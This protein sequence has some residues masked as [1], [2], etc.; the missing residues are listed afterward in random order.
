MERLFLN[1]T[2]G[3]LAATATVAQAGL[4][5]TTTLAEVLAFQQGL[6]VQTFEN[7]SGRTPFAVDA[8]PADGVALGSA[9][10]VYDQVPG[11][12]FS[13][14]FKPGEVMAGLFQVQV[15]NG[16]GDSS[17]NTVL[18]GLSPDN[19]TQFNP[20]ELIEAYLPHKVSRLGFWLSPDLG[21]VRVTF[22]NSNFAFNRDVDEE[23][24]ESVVVEA[25]QFVGL[26]RDNADIG[27][28]KISALSEF[29]FA[30]DDLSFGGTG[31]ANP[32]PEP[33]SAW[34]VAA[35]L[36]AS[37]SASRRPRRRAAK[38]GV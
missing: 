3:A 30:I 32:M 31:S 12:Q 9:A 23:V 4:I 33:A 19:A 38:V 25:G 2:L 36:L 17:S 5:T 1:L 14:G 21:K 22:L 18:A 24:W 11:F 27:G 10:L 8:Y 34:L 35:S 20:A 13:S 6:D 26:S 37:A 29:G 16:G 15:N 7:V 28:L